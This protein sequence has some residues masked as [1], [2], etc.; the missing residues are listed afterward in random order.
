MCM[1][2]CLCVCVGGGEG[3]WVDGCMY[4]CL[5]TN[6]YNINNNT[7]NNN[8]ILTYMFSSIYLSIHQGTASLLFL[9][10]QRGSLFL[11]K[12]IV[13]GKQIKELKLWGWIV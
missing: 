1:C 5:P 7:S 9:N 11:P 3:G 13:L 4:V 10:A 8:T 12:T 6:T 2:V